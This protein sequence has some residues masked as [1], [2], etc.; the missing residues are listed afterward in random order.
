VAAQATPAA[1]NRR[2]EVSKLLD[3]LPHRLVDAIAAA[4]VAEESIVEIV[5]DFGRKPLVRARCNADANAN[6]NA[7]DGGNRGRGR[8]VTLSPD[9]VTRE[10]LDEIVG[11]CSDF[12]EDNRSGI[13]GTLHRISAIKNRAGKIVGI[14]CRVGEAVTG[15]AEMVKDIV[16]EGLSVLLLGR[17][18]VGKTT[19]I[20][21]IARIL[22][23]EAFRRVVI[24]DTSNEIGGDGGHPNSADECLSRSSSH[25]RYA[26]V[27][28]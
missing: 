17:P 16:L 28:R 15:S 14:T 22:A 10:E 20:R 23:D 12:A 21:E 18:G 11:N 25:S 7:D 27:T 8:D 24:V 26:L 2:K 3:K 1:D 5:L 9:P 6:V 4:G 19:V 13:D